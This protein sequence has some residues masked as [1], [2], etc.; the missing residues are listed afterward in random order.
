[1]RSNIAFRDSWAIDFDD[2]SSFYDVAENV[3]VY[4]N[5]KTHGGGSKRIHN[6]LIV[7]PDV[8]V[9]G[10]GCYTAQS[11][12][13]SDVF[14]FENTCMLQQ[15]P[16]KPRVDQNGQHVA[17]LYDFNAHCGHRNGSDFEGW[18]AEPLAGSHNVYGVPGGE[19][20][21]AHAFVHAEIGENGPNCTLAFLQA[22]GHELGTR[23]TAP[24]TVDEMMSQARALLRMKF[25]DVAR[26]R[27]IERDRPIARDRPIERWR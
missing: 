15:N 1:M 9:D 17:A 25:D 16:L 12:M 18:P 6:N 19:A 8:P 24:L 13:V 26:D 22:H 3:C 2:G 21:R 5:V 14:F 23:V 27:P 7:H 4:G 10:H 20:A 11:S